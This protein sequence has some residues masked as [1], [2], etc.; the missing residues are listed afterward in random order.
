MKEVLKKLAEIEVERQ[1]EDKSKIEEWEGR[2]K[3]CQG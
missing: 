1:R 2:M 3:R